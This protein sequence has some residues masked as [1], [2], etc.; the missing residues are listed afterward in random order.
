[1][2]SQGVSA[3]LLDELFGKELAAKKPLHG[4]DEGPGSLEA[5]AALWE[6]LDGLRNYRIGERS[7]VFTLDG[8]GDEAVWSLLD[9]LGD[10]EV[11]LEV[12]GNRSYQAKETALAGLWR[13]KVT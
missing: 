9:V 10:G 6:I 11:T 13:V 7:I 5:A 3:E 12:Q 2:S 1:M 4:L 8:V